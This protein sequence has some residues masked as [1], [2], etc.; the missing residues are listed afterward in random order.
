MI[1]VVCWQFLFLV[2]ILYIFWLNKPAMG[3]AGVAK[4][5]DLANRQPATAHKQTVGLNLWIMG[6]PS[7]AVKK[8]KRSLHLCVSNRSAQRP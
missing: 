2:E 8:R 3:K 5:E 4:A 1:W 7:S 6:V